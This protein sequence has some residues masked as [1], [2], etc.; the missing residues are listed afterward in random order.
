MAAKKSAKV[1]PRALELK[2]LKEQIR[3]LSKAADG[4]RADLLGDYQPGAY[5]GF[6]IIE[7]SRNVL[8]QDLLE[9]ALGSLE[10]YKRA[11]SAM[12]IEFPKN[13]A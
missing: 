6:V 8:D 7:K 2:S 5:P 9:A 12:H 4:L 13:A 3:E 1:D 10:P 11:S